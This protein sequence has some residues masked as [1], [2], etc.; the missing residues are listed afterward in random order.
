MKL[1]EHNIESNK[2][3]CEF[4]DH[5]LSPDFPL[6]FQKTT[7]GCIVQQYAHTLMWRNNENLPVEGFVNS[8][9]WP[10]AK[11][12]FD[13]FCLETGVK[14]KTIFRAAINST[15]Y[16]PEIHSEI[17]VDHEFK[18]NNFILYLNEFSNGHTLIFD[19]NNN[20]IHDIVPKAL[21]GVIFGGELHAQQFCD[22]HERRV[23]LVITFI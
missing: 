21:K 9:Y 13:K 17:H 19:E 12:I 7:P 15:S 14:Y 10:A 3:I 5:V 18:H 6:F 8:Q 11:E 20:V 4:V 23:I 2:K 1:I 22:I 16:S